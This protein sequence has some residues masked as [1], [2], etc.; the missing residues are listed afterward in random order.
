MQTLVAHYLHWTC[1][2]IVRVG[3]IGYHNGTGLLISPN[4]I[5]LL[6]QLN[7]EVLELLN[8]ELLLTWAQNRLI[9]LTCVLDEGCCPT[10]S[11]IKVNFVVR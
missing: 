7:R 8:D 10:R 9:C 11:H 2:G 6:S 1:L 4:Q 5:Q 3:L